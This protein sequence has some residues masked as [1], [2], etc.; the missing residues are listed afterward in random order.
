MVFDDETLASSENSTCRHLTASNSLHVH[1]MQ[2][3]RGG[4]PT[5]TLQPLKVSKLE[6][7]A[8]LLSQW[9]MS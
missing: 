3:S 2:R 4:E 8:Q 7:L 5:A 6:Q 1:K 9:V